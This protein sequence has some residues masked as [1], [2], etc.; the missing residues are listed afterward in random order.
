MMNRILRE[1]SKEFDVVEVRHN[2][3]ILSKIDEEDENIREFVYE[4]DDFKLIFK[5]SPKYVN[6]VQSYQYFFFS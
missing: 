3:V 6:L 5:V 2:Q 4:F 1:L